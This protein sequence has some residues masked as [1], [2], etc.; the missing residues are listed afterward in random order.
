MDGVGDAAGTTDAL[1]YLPSTG[2]S[3]GTSCATD[4]ALLGSL[5]VPVPNS[6]D[7]RCNPDGT[8]LAMD[9]CA[10]DTTDQ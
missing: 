2:C 7:V 1:G 6:T 10:I 8:Q 4:R 3:K 9:S 5:L